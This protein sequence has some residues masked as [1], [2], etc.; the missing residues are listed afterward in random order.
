MALLIEDVQ[1]LEHPDCFDFTVIERLE[2][3]TG[4]TVRADDDELI[5]ARPNTP[6]QMPHK[7][8]A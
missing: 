1:W 4:F 7:S 3:I 2:A 8:A 5:C 6:C